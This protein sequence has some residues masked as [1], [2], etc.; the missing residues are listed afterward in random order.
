MRWFLLPIALLVISCLDKTTEPEDENHYYVHA[1]VDTTAVF[2]GY[3]LSCS[4]SDCYGYVLKR[5]TYDNYELYDNSHGDILSVLVKFRLLLL[6]RRWP[7]WESNYDSLGINYYQRLDLETSGGI[8]FFYDSTYAPL[9]GYEN[10][11]EDYYWRSYAPND[12]LLYFKSSDCF[13][14]KL[15]FHA[16]RTEIQTTVPMIQSWEDTIALPYNYEFEMWVNLDGS[17]DF[18]WT[19]DK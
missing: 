13:Y 5:I 1:V 9:K 8:R 18:S 12:S 4:G 15:L 14:G 7:P 10:E 6:D 3:D 11:I 17:R 16:M 19:L 2:Y